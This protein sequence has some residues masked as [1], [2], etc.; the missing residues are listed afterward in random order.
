MSVLLLPIVLVLGVLLIVIVW[1]WTGPIIAFVVFAVVA[2][3]A[4]WL[5]QERKRR[6]RYGD[7]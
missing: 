7:D 4:S 2:S 6:A 5:V 3:L 1:A